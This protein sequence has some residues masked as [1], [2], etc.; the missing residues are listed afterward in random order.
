[1]QYNTLSFITAPG[2]YEPLNTRFTIPTGSIQYVVEV[3]VRADDISENPETF[4]V[5]L[6]NPS[7]GA[8]IAQPVSTIT[9][10]SLVGK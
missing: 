5:I 2:D 10:I 7:I 8:L 6:S 4:R 9:I 3:Q 1:M